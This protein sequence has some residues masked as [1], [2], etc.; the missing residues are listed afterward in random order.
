MI[1]MG[2]LLLLMTMTKVMTI[3]V[4]TTKMKALS[5]PPPPLFLPAQ[6]PKDAGDGH[7]GQ[8]PPPLGGHRPVAQLLVGPGH[9]SRLHGNGL[10]RHG[11]R[12][13]GV[14]RGPPGGSRGLSA[15]QD[16]EG[17]TRG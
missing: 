14:P 9:E 17:V 11:P 8:D 16:P 5:H 15:P 2:I 4:T 12:S 13:R 3:A 10:R 7:P 1:I 6:T